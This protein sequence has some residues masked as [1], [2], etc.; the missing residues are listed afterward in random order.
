MVDFKP[1][2]QQDIEVVTGMMQ[3]FYGI[4]NY[5]MDAEKS[6]RLLKEFIVNDSLGSAWL[7]LHNGQPVGYVILTF[8]FSFEYGGRIAFLDE[9]F[10]GSEARGFGLGKKTLDFIHTEAQ[11]LGIRII[12]LEVEHHN[13][14]ARN[15]Y[16]SKNYTIHTRNLM[17]LIV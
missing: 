16:L 9:L 10:I 7:I 17:K 13:E 12:Y 14:T 6:K 5:P 2:A 15:L 1:I 4:D 11:K 3:E 8:V